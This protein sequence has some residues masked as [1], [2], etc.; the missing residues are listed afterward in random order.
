LVC[1]FWTLEFLLL[2]VSSSGGSRLYVGQRVNLTCTLGH[3]LDPDLEVKWKCRSCSSLHSSP[4]LSIPEVTME[5]SG[6]WTCELWKNETRLTYAVLSLKIGKRSER[7]I[8]SDACAIKCVT[9][10]LPINCFTEKAP[11]DIW[12]CV[13]ISCGVVVF[14]LLL[15]IAVIGIRRHKQVN[16]HCD[17]QEWFSFNSTHCCHPWSVWKVKIKCLMSFILLN[18]LWCTDDERP[19]SAAA[20]REFGGCYARHAYNNVFGH[21]LKTYEWHFIIEQNVIFISVILFFKYKTF[22]KIS[23]KIWYWPFFGWIMTW[24]ITPELQLLDKSV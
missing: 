2:L 14:I 4:F 22:H 21:T 19:D 7:K 24:L 20:K 5:H 11:V 3:P 9:C 8:E 10:L 1:S 12:L 17:T 13:A 16:V 18:R 15:V 23:S 6:Q